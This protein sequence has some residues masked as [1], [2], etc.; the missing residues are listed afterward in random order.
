MKHFPI[1]TK[2]KININY[3]RKYLQGEYELHKDYTVLGVIKNKYYA[4]GV[5]FYEV[6]WDDDKL[7]R[8]YNYEFLQEIYDVNQIMKQLL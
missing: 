2:V 6:L 3:I 5:D 1:G 8:G 4:D 7:E